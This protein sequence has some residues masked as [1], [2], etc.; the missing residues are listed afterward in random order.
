MGTFALDMAD[1]SQVGAI[2]RYAVGR[3]E[4][5]GF[6]EAD[7]GRV[8]IVATELATNILKHAEYGEM[9]VADFDDASGMG[10]EMLALD[11]GPG[12]ADI[13]AC[14]RDG[15]STA[16]SAGHGLG[17]VRRQAQTFD[18]ISSLAA[19]TAVLA[20]LSA[21]RAMPTRATHDFC[22]GA[23]T[24][25]KHGET[26]CGDAWCAIAESES[27]ECRV[28][29]ADGLGH[30]P[31]AASAAIEAVSLFQRHVD[32]ALSAVIERIHEGLRHTRGAAVAIAH[33]QPRQQRVLFCGIGNIAATILAAGQAR[34]TVSQNGTAGLSVRRIQVFE[35][36]LPCPF[37][38]IMHTDGLTTNWS[39][40]RYPGWSA[41]HPTLIAGVLYRDFSRAR[42][43]ATVLV[44]H[45]AAA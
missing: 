45:G 7:T 30:G 9:I 8:A 16:S 35:Y 1:P 27:G 31:L 15:Y 37:H 38:F 17:A 21:G 26:V 41:A 19:G 39:I 13:A 32:D 34:R 22:L 2:R 14:L 25:P 12:I 23:V 18:I 42:D 4:A 24:V 33:L 28:M 36:D 29:V 40:E 10:V 44:A 3:A 11:R 5:L 20:R 43:D 6:D